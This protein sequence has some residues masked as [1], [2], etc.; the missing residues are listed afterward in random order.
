MKRTMMMIGLTGAMAVSGSL[1]VMAH[2]CGNWGAA[3]LGFLGGVIVERSA[4]GHRG[5]YGCER[6]VVVQENYCPQPVVVQ[7]Y[8]PQPVYVQQQPSGHYEYRQEQ[9]WVPG[10]S[11]FEQIDVNTYRKVSCP[12]HY[13]TVQTKVWVQDACN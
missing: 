6:P 8:A 10:E 3:A 13:V 5:Y 4:E 12:G 1:P 7:T 9:Q 2:G 11:H